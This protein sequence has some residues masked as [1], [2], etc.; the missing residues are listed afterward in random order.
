M[1]EAERSEG[2]INFEGC[3]LVF[4]T[5]HHVH[6]AKFSSEFLSLEV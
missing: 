5:S 1:D 2:K 3:K 4:L 6:C